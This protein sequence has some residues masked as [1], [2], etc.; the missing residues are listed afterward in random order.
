MEDFY[1]SIIYL[2]GFVVSFFVYVFVLTYLDTGKH[3]EWNHYLDSGIGN[4]V[5]AF[6]IAW[7]WPLSIIV[8]V[9]LLLLYWVIRLVYWVKK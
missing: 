2:T 8:S 3:K 7:V 9:F 6:L 1:I 4:V 5:I